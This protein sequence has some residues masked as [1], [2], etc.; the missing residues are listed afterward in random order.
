MTNPIAHSN[1]TTTHGSVSGERPWALT[2]ITFTAYDSDN[3]TT[4]THQTPIKEGRALLELIGFDPTDCGMDIHLPGEDL[5][6]RIRQVREVLQ[7]VGAPHRH[8]LED[9][10]SRLIELG[11]QAQEAGHQVTWGR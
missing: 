8:I 7:Y 3:T 6:R 2:T 11:E 5:A 1:T 9:H 4:A 10:F